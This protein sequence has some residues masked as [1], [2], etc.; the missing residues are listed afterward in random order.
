MSWVETD[1]YEAAH[2]R[3]PR[4]RQEW[5][6]V[7]TS[8]AGVLTEFAPGERLYSDAKRWALARARQLSAFKIE[9]AV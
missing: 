3:K 1:K 4:G 6:F 8:A 5:R 7:F 2:G 9:S